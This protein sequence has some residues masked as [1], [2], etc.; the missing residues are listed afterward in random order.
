MDNNKT[1]TKQTE[2]YTPGFQGVCLSKSVDEIEE[3]YNKGIK[4]KFHNEDNVEWVA[5]N[6]EL[7]KEYWDYP[8]F[9]WSTYNSGFKTTVQNA[10]T[11]TLTQLGSDTAHPDRGTTF[12]E[13]AVEGSIIDVD[14][15]KHSA[16]FAA[17]EVRTYIND[18]TDPIFKEGFFED[19]EN[20]FVTETQLIE[21]S[22]TPTITNYY[23]TPSKLDYDR[24]QLEAYFLSS[25]GE[26]IGLNLEESLVN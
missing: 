22:L 15:L 26:S 14:Q 11:D 12:H 6:P 2:K 24:V 23:L 3:N 21:G 8:D 17:E 18:N 20:A 16:N 9:D 1:S 10:L 19:S 25:S 4:L 7:E 5:G 13:E